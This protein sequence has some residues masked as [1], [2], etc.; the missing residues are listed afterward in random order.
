MMLLVSVI[1]APLTLI[2]TKFPIFTNYA[3]GTKIIWLCWFNFSI[4]P[5]LAI[6]T[7]AFNE[8]NYFYNTETVAEG[9]FGLI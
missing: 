4:D 5:E 3:Y 1:K 9:T 7:T 8:C 2:W 6:L